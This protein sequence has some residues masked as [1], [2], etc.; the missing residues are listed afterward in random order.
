M[1]KEVIILVVNTLVGEK[2]NLKRR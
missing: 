1:L 2:Q